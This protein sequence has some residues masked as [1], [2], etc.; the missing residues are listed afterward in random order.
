MMNKFKNSFDDYVCSGHAIL[1]ISTHEK[2]RAIQ[3]IREVAEE[4]KRNVWVWSIASGWKLVKTPTEDTEDTQEQYPSGSNADKMSSV[5]DPVVCLKTIPQFAE[6]S[7]LILKDFYFY[8]NHKTYPGCDIVVS[9]LDELKESL[10]GQGQTIVIVGPESDIPTCLKHDVT[11]I[12]FNLPTK[13][14]IENS[15]KFV[16][17]GVTGENG[18]QIKIECDNTEDVVGACKGMT[19]HQTIDRLALAIRKHKNLNKEAVRT[20]INEKASVIK[21]SGLLTYIE[22]PPGGLDVVGG[23]D[24]LKRH[25][26]LDKPC[27]QDEAIDFGIEFPKGILMVGVPGCGKTLLSTAIASEFG[28]SLI[29]MD[30]G[31]LMKKWVGESEANMREAIKIIE[32]MAP[33]V[34]QLD[35]IEKGFGGNSDDGGSSK[36]VFGT[37]LK[38]LS[39]HTSPVYVVATANEVQSLPPE[40]SRK[41]RFDEIFGLDL[42]EKQEREDIFSIHL[43]KRKR[44]P[45]DFNLDALAAASESFTGADIEQA[46]KLGLKIAFQA[47]ETN[48]K[49]KQSHIEIAIEGIIPLYKSDPLRID[50]I[51]KWVQERAKLANP[52]KN[53]QSKTKSRKVT[54]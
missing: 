5:V 29:A 14:D 28:F 23:Y 3:H 32:S 41:G 6:N 20:L 34:L 13:N 9:C 48:R 37:F 17:E 33:C 24:A 38:W 26:T 50:G 30:I 15:I 47:S 52:K 16:S 11:S 25:V 19:Q 18:E 31:S 8:L 2:D 53:P 4:S 54:I 46:I 21:S 1:S 51:R 43:T 49:L 45:K 39:D 27:F 35:E 10:S 36:R 12:D 44:N 42:P 7:I 40:L 22:P